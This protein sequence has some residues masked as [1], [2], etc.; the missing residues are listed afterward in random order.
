M[1]LRRKEEVKTCMGLRGHV[2]TQHTQTH[3]HVRLLLLHVRGREEIWFL[4]LGAGGVGCYS[5]V[6][7]GRDVSNQI[8][9][10]KREI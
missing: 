6:T 4:G 2:H 10:G 9:R 1:G 3:M 8:T 7:T 5:T